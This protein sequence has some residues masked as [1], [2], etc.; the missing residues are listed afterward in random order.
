[1]LVTYLL[2]TS[3][4]LGAQV[5]AG[6]PGANGERERRTGLLARN[7]GGQRGRLGRVRG[8][9][10]VPHARRRLLHTFA[11]LSSQRDLYVAAIR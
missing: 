7:R 5:L 2:C 3:V 8:A 1:M 6:A 10:R 9:R 11:T 4:R